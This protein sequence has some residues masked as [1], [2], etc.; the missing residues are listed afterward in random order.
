[1]AFAKSLNEVQVDSSAAM[2]LNQHGYLGL[3]I[4]VL[5]VVV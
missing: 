3:M 4:E 1:M 5:V 2:A